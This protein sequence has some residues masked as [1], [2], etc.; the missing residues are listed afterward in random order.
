M[1]DKRAA[2]DC[3]PC[4]QIRPP[5]LADRA[6]RAFRRSDSG[7]DHARRDA[8]LVI[9]DVVHG[10]VQ[11]CWPASDQLIYRQADH[12]LGEAGVQLITSPAIVSIRTA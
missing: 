4:K 8:A 9:A 5:V 7:F 12:D 3:L 6:T 2:S 1:L 11:L 10:S